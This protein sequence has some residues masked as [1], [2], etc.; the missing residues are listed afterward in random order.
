MLLFYLVSRRD[1]LLVLFDLGFLA[2][3]ERLEATHSPLGGGQNRAHKD[4]EYDS[5][6][7]N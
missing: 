4:N 1:V 5:K 2:K 3:R 6:A 7:K